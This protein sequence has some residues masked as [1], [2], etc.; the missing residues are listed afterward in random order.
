KEILGATLLTIHNEYFTVK[1]VDEIRA[2]ILDG[3][4]FEFKQEFLSRY[5]EKSRNA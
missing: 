4:Y 3:S 2:R 1:L 5:Y